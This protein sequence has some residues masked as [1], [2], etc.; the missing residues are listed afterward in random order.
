MPRARL[1]TSASASAS[2]GYG[3]KRV[4][5]RAGPNAVEWIAM[6]ARRPLGS[7][8]QYTTCSG[9]P[10]W[11]G[12]GEGVDTGALVAAVLVTALDS[13]SSAQSSLPP[14][15]EPAGPRVPQR[16]LPP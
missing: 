15:V 16:C 5:P 12:E 8:W 4:P 11:N 13:F 6:M 1:R 10:D 3:W 7:S 14:S 2:V 9:P